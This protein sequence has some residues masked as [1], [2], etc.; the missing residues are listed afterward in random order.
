MLHTLRCSS[1]PLALVQLH[2][3][4]IFLGV[5]S[6]H[7]LCCD[8]FT[9]A[10]DDENRGLL[11]NCPTSGCR[12]VWGNLLATPSSKCRAIGHCPGSQARCQQTPELGGLHGSCEGPTPLLWPA[13]QPEASGVQAEA[14]RSVLQQPTAL[15]ALEGAGSL[16]L[17]DGDAA[18]QPFSIFAHSGAEEGKSLVPTPVKEKLNRNL[19]GS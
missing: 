6:V 9:N 19:F 11:H 8:C 10:Q 4:L 2:M 14:S 18:L 12:Q 3:Y 7:L 17:P 5:Y 15:P 1:Y 16:Q 13:H